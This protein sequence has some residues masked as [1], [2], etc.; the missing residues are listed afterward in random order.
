MIDYATL[1]TGADGAMSKG[2]IYIRG[3]KSKDG[4]DSF[5][6]VLEKNQDFCGLD[7]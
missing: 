6:F 5:K 3:I 2:S 1:S 4:Y 7:A